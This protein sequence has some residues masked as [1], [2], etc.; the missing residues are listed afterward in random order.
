[1]KRREK[2]HHVFLVP[3]FFG[4][5]N[6]GDFYYF[7]HLRDLLEDYLHKLGV[8]PQVTRVH[9]HPT[10]SL[11][12]RARKLA[13]TIRETAGRDKH[14]IH[15]V[16]HSTGGLD[17]RLLTSPGAS[18]GDG[19][20]PEPVARRVRTV[21]TVATPHYGTP[22]ASFFAT[23]LG[24]RLLQLLTLAT[25]YGLRFGHVPLSFLLKLGAVFLRVDDV[26]GWR[27]N[28]LDQLFDQ[29]LARFTSDRRA[30]VEGFLKEVGEDQALM[31]Q[32]TPDSMDMFNAAATDRPG[33]RYGSVLTRVEPPR[34][35]TRMA[36]GLDPYAQ[37]TY[38]IFEILHG[39]TA[40]MK[41]SHAFDAGSAAYGFIREQ[42][43]MIPSPDD[44]DGIVPTLSQAWGRPLAAVNADHLDVIG[45]FE[46]R[47]TDPPHV[48]WL[49]SGSS[50]DRGRFEKLW[51]D[52]ARFM[53]ERD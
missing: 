12:Q 53:L 34:L 45:H 2:R 15:L 22:L 20:D 47:S 30:M 14:P 49:S 43:G 48:D 16:G 44:N 39:R 52:V 19:I 13:E 8:K 6:L 27:N 33:V 9:T 10:A 1:M 35:G 29:L 26:F 28:L 41:A 40:G 4:F 32:L 31:M 18:L 51:K 23:M 46:D 25:A 3:G 21:V 37:A 7:G 11:R 50:F 42:L 5:V 17:A 38:G 36:I 24:Q